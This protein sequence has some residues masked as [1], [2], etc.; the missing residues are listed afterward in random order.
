MRD[1]HARD[2]IATLALVCVGA[3]GERVSN[4]SADLLS[5]SLQFELPS[6]R[7]LLVGFWL[8]REFVENK[9]N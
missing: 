2:L 5:I 6:L 1:I 9:I 8:P 4:L 7:S 3:A